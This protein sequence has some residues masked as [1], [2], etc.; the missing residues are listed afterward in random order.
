M[1]TEFAYDL[2]KSN[3]QTFDIE[4]SD[5]GLINMVRLDFLSNHGNHQHTCIYRL[6]VH[7]HESD[8]LATLAV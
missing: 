6:R 2:E 3:A 5:A 7:G 1:L 8:S 4:V